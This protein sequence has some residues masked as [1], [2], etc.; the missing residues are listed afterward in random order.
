[1]GGWIDALVVEFNATTQLFN[2]NVQP[3]AQPNKVRALPE[4]FDVQY[5]STSSQQWIPTRVRGYN[6]RN[7][8]YQLDCHPE[9]IPTRVRVPPVAQPS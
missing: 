3:M 2:L 7:Q 4:G 8:T 5:H 6:P 9:A 1:M